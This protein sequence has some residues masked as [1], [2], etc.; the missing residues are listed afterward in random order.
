MTLY[1]GLPQEQWDLLV[2]QAEDLFY[3]EKLGQHIVGIYPAGPRVYGIES[4]PPGLLC[5]YC[6]NI[7]KLINPLSPDVDG[8]YAF[9]VGHSRSAIIFA[10]LFKW[11][12]WITTERQYGW[13]TECLMHIIPCNQISIHEDDSIT[14]LIDDITRLLDKVAYCSKY[15]PDRTGSEMSV[16]WNMMQYTEL[17]DRM[18]LILALTREFRPNIHPD[19]DAVF[20]LS[21]LPIQVPDEVLD[22]DA[23]LR[24]NRIENIDFSD[25][26]D[27]Y[28]TYQEWLTTT[29][30]NI[31]E[32]D[33]LKLDDLLLHKISQQSVRLF[34]SQI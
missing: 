20:E 34:S 24:H 18:L 10:D 15:R 25:Q 31:V 32:P 14:P 19:W 9:R 27:R 1:Y 22:Y 2:S 28:K 23:I 21:K 33:K 8:F 4:E 30:D 3:D 12:R 26:L 11:I 6:D 7:L 29:Y 5:L 17:Y 16:R 13:K